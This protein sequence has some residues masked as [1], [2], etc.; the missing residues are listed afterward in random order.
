MEQTKPRLGR[1]L[2]ALLGA[3]NGGGVLGIGASVGKVRLDQ[4]HQNPYQPRK[5]FDD[6]ELKQLADSIKVHGVLQP[7]VVRQ[8]GETYQL[9]AGERRLRAATL[10]GLPEVP[11][12]VVGFDDQQVY[13]AALVE[14][15]QRSDLNPIEKAQGFKDYLEKYGLTH[16]A[17]G[18]RLGLDRS[19]ISNL[20]GLL[21]L[22]A[23]VQDAV[24]LGQLSLGHAKVLKGVSDTEKQKE[25]A[26]EAIFRH[27]SV[28]AL[29]LLAREAKAEVAEQKGEKPVRLA[30]EKTSHVQSLEDDLRQRLATR[31]E[32]KVKAK[33][34]GQIV[35]GFDSNDDFE[36]IMAALTK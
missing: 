27:L 29:D 33:E 7:L 9:I 3:V 6:D 11:V 13:E 30:V 31:V 25:L 14:N 12:H 20:V 34:K 24:R 23:E 36:R 5:R 4:I 26:R 21:N 8:A 17:L 19:S 22:P 1:G 32:I 28:H 35:I 2:D 10:A 18:Q 15:I 16:E